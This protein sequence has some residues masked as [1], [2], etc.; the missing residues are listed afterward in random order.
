[1]ALRSLGDLCF[2]EGRQWTQSGLKRFAKDKELLL[3][4]GLLAEAVATIAR[5]RAPAAAGVTPG[6]LELMRQRQIESHS[7][8]GEAASS[9]QQ[10]LAADAAS[11]E[12]SLHLGRVRYRQGQLGPALQALEPVIARSRER[13]WLYLAYL[14]AGRVHE[15]A[16]RAGDA[17]R[18]YQNAAR[19]EPDGQAAAM[20]LAHVRLMAGDTGETREI[21]DKELGR[22]VPRS[23]ADP[24]W[25][26]QLGAARRADRLFEAMR[27]EATAR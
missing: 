17:E 19:V 6:E 4:R 23:H 2:E 18:A 7:L 25:D 15:A 22:S 24:F 13:G 20:A 27:A 5:L 26:Y 9:Y 10:A 1:M 3:A 16:G 21:L 12:A 8:L 11:D 14:F